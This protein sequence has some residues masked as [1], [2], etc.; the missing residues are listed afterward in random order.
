ML[1][2]QCPGPSS[3]CDHNSCFLCLELQR[4]GDSPHTGESM[5]MS[6]TRTTDPWVF[7]QGP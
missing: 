4:A 3:R 5:V 2:E 6:G 7:S 1:V